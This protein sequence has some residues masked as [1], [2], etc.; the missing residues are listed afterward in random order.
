MR[1]Y[2]GRRRVSAEKGQA[3][4]EFAIIIPLLLLLVVGIIEFGKAFNYWIDLNHLA[5]EGARWAA[6]EKVPPAN[7]SPGPNDIR[8]YLIGQA[9]ST[10]LESAI[11]PDGGGP[12]GAGTSNVGICYTP[13]PIEGYVGTPPP[14]IGDAVTVTIEA[15]YSFPVISGLINLAGRLFGAGGG[16]IGDIT[17]RGES[18]M[19]LEQLPPSTYTTPQ[20]NDNYWTPCKTTTPDPPTITP[21]GWTGNTETTPPWPDSTFNLS[22]TDPDATFECSIDGAAYQTCTT[23]KTYTNLTN[24]GASHTLKVIARDPAGGISAPT[25]YTWTIS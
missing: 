16:S 5:N 21:E 13:T 9:S 12:I 2:G 23:P 8:N 15:P 7:S 19:R 11:A 1:K 4:I 25:I 20:P 24:G 18:T 10:E 22:D 17:L 14:Q 3:T 6:V